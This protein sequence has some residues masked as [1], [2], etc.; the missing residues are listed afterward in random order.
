M[1][2]TELHLEA[3]VANNNWYSA[4]C[5]AGK[6]YMLGATQYLL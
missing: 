1:V 3:H 2:V 5:A 6:L 4:N